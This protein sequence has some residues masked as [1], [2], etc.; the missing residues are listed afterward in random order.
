M[1]SN[2]SSLEKLPDISQWNV[3]NVENM[4][5]LIYKCK[6]NFLPNILKWKTSKL[7]SAYNIIEGC[8]S[9][10]EL[11]SLKIFDF[12]NEQKDKFDSKKKKYK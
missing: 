6:L 5:Y 1:F 7:T 10:F 11:Y 2:C 4:D 9:Y 3:S 8:F 12:S